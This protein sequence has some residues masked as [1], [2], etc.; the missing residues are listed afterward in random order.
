VFLFLG[1]ILFA[2]GFLR[3]Q[4]HITLAKHILNFN[5]LL[6]FVLLVWI[7]Y[8]FKTNLFVL[9]NLSL[10]QNRFLFH[11]ALLP[12]KNKWL[13]LAK[14][15]FQL[16]VPIILYAFFMMVVGWFENRFL[17]ISIILLFFIVS[18]FFGVLVYENRIMKHPQKNENAI[19]KILKQAAFRLS[20]F[21]FSPAFLINKEPILF[22]LSKIGSLL[23]IIFTFWLYPTDRYDWR[24]FALMVIMLSAIH[25][26]IIATFFSFWEGWLS[27]FR[28]LPLSYFSLTK[29]TMVSYVLIILPEILLIG[30]RGKEYFSWIFL[31][32]LIIFF[33][34]FIT[35]LH[36][37]Q[38]LYIVSS[39]AKYQIYFFGFL[40]V[41]LL[42]MFKIP[43]WAFSILFL[44]MSFYIVS[45]EW[46][47]YEYAYEN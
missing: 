10:M 39:K 15:Q 21:M 25:Y 1:I 22:L 30:F 12:S 4:E 47:N 24:L 5:S 19:P 14:V 8:I 28:N 34:S 13:A 7:I 26:Q 16:L 38:Y 32:S 9:R 40:V 31:I 3:G 27:I 11:I 17:Q 44:V 20:P 46:K 2:F 6:I 18:I 33:V 23:F 45:Q 42:I 35:I 41:F 36:Y 29:I 37:I 43:L